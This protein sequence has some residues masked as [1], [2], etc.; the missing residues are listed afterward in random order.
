M[1]INDIISVVC[2]EEKKPSTPLPAPAM[3]DPRANL[4][5][6]I[7]NAGGAGRAKLRSTTETTSKVSLLDILLCSSL[8][9]PDCVVVNG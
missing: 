5:E 2:R 7:R 4:M 6:A 3:G 9:L 1:S 8:D